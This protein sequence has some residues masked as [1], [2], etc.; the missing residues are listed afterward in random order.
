[1]WYRILVFVTPELTPEDEAA[2]TYCSPMEND[3]VPVIFREVN[4]LT[5]GI[6]ELVVLELQRLGM[7][8]AMG[9][10]DQSF[11]I[12]AVRTHVHTHLGGGMPPDAVH[13]ASMSPATRKML[14]GLSDERVAQIFYTSSSLKVQEDTLR[15]TARL[16]DSPRAKFFRWK[17]EVFTL[18]SPEAI[19][20]LGKDAKTY[21][22]IVAIKKATDD[23]C[24][25]SDD[26][27]AFESG[28]IHLRDAFKHL[29]KAGLQRDFMLPDVDGGFSNELE[30]MDGEK[31]L[32]ELLVSFG[33]Q[34]DTRVYPTKDEFL[35]IKA[36]REEVLRRLAERDRLVAQS[37]EGRTV[38][39]QT[40]DPKPN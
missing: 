2:R 26:R 1:M 27:L 10:S 21:H 36:L 23:L 33:G 12:A 38:D 34:E 39:V 24:E 20:A 35:K 17:D 19:N 3:Q 16:G 22:C 15:E 18:M 5:R 30:D 25:R 11:L 4:R 29:V 9:P 14:A 6:L 40:G 7:P 28:V 8:S 37:K 13:P 32:R 31:L